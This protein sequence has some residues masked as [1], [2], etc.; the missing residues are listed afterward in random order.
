MKKLILILF[1]LFAYGG[2]AQVTIRPGVTADSLKGG[3][4]DPAFTASV[5]AGI[6]STQT[7]E[8]STAYGWGD[9]SGLYDNAGTASSTVMAHNIEFNHG[10]IANG[11]TAYGWGDHASGGYESASNKT[12][13][14]GTSTTKYA[15]QNLVK[16]YNDSVAALMKRKA[17]I[18]PLYGGGVDSTL[19]LTTLKFPLGYSNGI[20]IDTI[21]FI[22]TTIGA[23]TT[24]VTPK[25]FYGTDIE[26]SGTAIV[27][28]PSAVTSHT[29][30]TKVSSFDNA[31]VAVGNMIWLTFTDV[32]TKP[33]NFMVQIIGHKQ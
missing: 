10:N 7:V 25:L 23:G 1:I 29:T 13:V 11:Q 5:A 8:W 12:N 16:A 18:V 17:D 31:T 33:R 28:S 2:Y 6:T 4:L 20:V 3:E 14:T 19:M 30:A 32:T 26:A 21:V 24:N 22:S 9:H 15:T 27:T